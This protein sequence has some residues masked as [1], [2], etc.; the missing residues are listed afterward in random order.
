MTLTWLISMSVVGGMP[1][2]ITNSY[3]QSDGWQIL[4][5]ETKE[6]SPQLAIM[7]EYAIRI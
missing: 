4:R 7:T 1:Y 2:F 5:E 6:I 3:A